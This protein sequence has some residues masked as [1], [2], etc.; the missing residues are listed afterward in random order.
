MWPMQNVNIFVEQKAS[1]G[2]PHSKVS[3]SL[4]YNLLAKIKHHDTLIVI[5][6]NG[7]AVLSVLRR[8]FSTLLK[9]YN[10]KC[11]QRKPQSLDRLSNRLPNP[12]RRHHCSIAA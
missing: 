11:Q 6:A 2:R 9:T 12:V 8:A 1:I 4:P 5:F 3:L 10:I 7:G